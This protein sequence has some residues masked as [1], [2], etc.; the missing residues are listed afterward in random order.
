MKVMDARDF[1]YVF[2]V[3]V[4][5][6]RPLLCIIFSLRSVDLFIEPIEVNSHFPCTFITFLARQKLSSL[7]SVLS[8]LTIT[9][10][11]FNR[12]LKCALFHKSF[13]SFQ[14]YI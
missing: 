7:L 1:I 10:S 14:L 5:G 6:Q 3:A 9:H 13:G 8:S 4:T 11:L 2:F 12:G